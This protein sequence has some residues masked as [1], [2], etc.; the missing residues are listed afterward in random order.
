MIFNKVIQTKVLKALITVFRVILISLL[1]V[2]MAAAMRKLLLSSLENKVVWI[3]FYPAVMIAAISAGFFGGLLSSVLTCILI[4]TH[5]DFFT[6]QPF[7]INNADWIGLYVFLINCFLISGITESSRIQHKKAKLAKQEA[8][9]ANKSKSLFLANMS[10]ELRTPLNAILGFSQLMQKNKKMPEDEIENLDIINRSGEHLLSLINDVL[11]I[12]KIESGKM[13]LDVTPS[14]LKEELL[15]IK[16]LLSQKAESKK[17]D[18]IF[19]VQEELPNYIKADILKIKQIIINLLGNAIK[20]TEEGFVKTSIRYAEDSQ[21]KILL[22]III[23]DSGNG[24]PSDQLDNIFKPFVQIG[25]NSTKGTGLGLTISKRY[26]ELMGGK[27]TVQSKIG[28]GSRFFVE[29]PLEKISDTEI[30]KNETMQFSNIQTVTEK[31]K[32][33]KVLIVEDKIENWL[34]L[35]RILETIS[36][37]HIKIAENGKEGFDIFKEFHPDIIFMDIRMDVMNGIEATKAIRELEH[38]KDVKIVAITAHAF[39]EELQNLLHIGFDLYIKKP[40]KYNEIYT[41]LHEL[42]GVEYILEDANQNQ[43]EAENNELP[44]FNKSIKVLMAEDDAINQKLAIA[45][46]KKLDLDYD[47]ASNGENAISLVQ[48]NTYTLIFLDLEMPGLNG[49]ETTQRIRNLAS[50]KAKTPIIILSSHEKNEYKETLSELGIDDFISK[51]VTADKILTAVLKFTS[52]KIS[53]KEDIAV[54]P[55]TEIFDKKLLLSRIYEDQDLFQQI[56]IALENDL[57]NGINELAQSIRDENYKSINS[58]AHRLKGMTLTTCTARLANLFKEIETESKNTNM[59]KIAELFASIKIEE[60]RL[61]P[62]IK[63]EIM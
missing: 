28:T 60:K 43:F 20:F 57:Q 17:L 21:N 27:I 34:L 58:I 12:S 16:K 31:Y 44:Q 14:N 61:L 37:T 49:L 63:E 8:D 19:E 52:N 9:L 1:T 10:H 7:I 11:D 4:I 22:K 38:G 47:L 45:T 18:F 6:T 35:K 23:E 36:I 33:L 39:K 13:F 48:K 50:E 41:C 3:T 40:Y 29:I 25:N 54:I 32:N 62:I 24:I 56:M 30:I 42:L 5:W 15:N 51:P 46:F 26:I 55:D 53:I 2:L 59:N